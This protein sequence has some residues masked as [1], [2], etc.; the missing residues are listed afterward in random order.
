MKTSLSARIAAV[1][2]LASLGIPSARALRS[3]QLPTSAN[4]TSN[5]VTGGDPEPFSPDVIYAILVVLH[6]V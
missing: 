4:I 2:L 5:S 1:L 3:D 6:C